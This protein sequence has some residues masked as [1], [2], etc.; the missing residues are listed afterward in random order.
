MDPKV[1][2]LEPRIFPQHA[3]PGPLVAE[4]DKVRGSHS[5]WTRT[6]TFL[7]AQGNIGASERGPSW[8]EPGAQ[9]PHDTE[10]GTPFPLDC[11]RAFLVTQGRWRS[12]VVPLGT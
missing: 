9:G 12:E 5:T 2:V 7:A 4:E 10:L 3:W 8:S 1:S 6:R 11:P